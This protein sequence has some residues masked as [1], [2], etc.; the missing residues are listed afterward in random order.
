MKLK[1]LKCV[2]GP[3]FMPLLSKSYGGPCEQALR[4]QRIENRY[5]LD[6]DLCNQIHLN[7]GIGPFACA[8]IWGTLGMI[9]III[10]NIKILKIHEYYK[11][12]YQSSSSNVA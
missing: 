1:F 12:W 10:L 2:P 3:F 9:Y 6:G 5:P 7:F 8:K 11:Y 4:Y